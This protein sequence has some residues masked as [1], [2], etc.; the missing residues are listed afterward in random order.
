[1]LPLNEDISQSRLCSIKH[2]AVELIELLVVHTYI[3][4]TRL[5]SSMLYAGY[6]HQDQAKST[7]LLK[8]IKTYIPQVV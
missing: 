1:M 8:L 7:E 4:C 5:S 3:A 6:H 2:V